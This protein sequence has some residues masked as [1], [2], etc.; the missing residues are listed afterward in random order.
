MKKT[1]SR[2]GDKFV[3]VQCFKKSGKVYTDE[4]MD[5]YV[6]IDCYDEILKERKRKAGELK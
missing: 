3:C 4:N 1:I 2:E 5:C 6:C